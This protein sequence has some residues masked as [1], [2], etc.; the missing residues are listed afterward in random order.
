MNAAWAV[1]SF[2]HA[3]LTGIVE[4]HSEHLEREPTFLLQ[5]LIQIPT[6]WQLST[7]ERH[8]GRLSQYNHFG[9]PRVLW[10]KALALI[11]SCPCAPPGEQWQLPCTRLR[12]SPTYVFSGTHRALMICGR[13]LPRE[14]S[15]Y[16]AFAVR[17]LLWTNHAS[18]SDKDAG[19]V[20]GIVYQMY[21]EGAVPSE[22]VSDGAQFDVAFKKA[23]RIYSRPLGLRWLLV[24][25]FQHDRDALKMSVD[26]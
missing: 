26:P 15:R 19:N 22:G 11:H 17:C 24:K 1:F 21:H 20:L 2:L 16:R 5:C 3:S 6:A 4:R 8:F 9:V 14:S 25:L 23:V 18:G 10:K 7:L 12:I 13:N